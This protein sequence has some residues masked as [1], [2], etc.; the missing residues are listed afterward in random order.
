MHDPF[1]LPPI[2][3]LSEAVQPL[4]DSLHF[5]TLPLHIHEV[6]ISF[7]T[8]TFVDAVGAPF[9]SSRLFPVSYA[10]LS[11]ER[12][13]NW[14]VHVVS[15][16]QSVIINI[17]A[18]WIL[19]VDQ[20][21]KNM[22]LEERIWGYTGAAGMVQALAAGY[23]LWDLLISL[24]HIR[25]F[26]IGI[27]A[28]AVSA[29]V[30]FSFGFRPFVNYY[31]CTFILYELS[32][33]FLNF[34]W[35]FD[36]LGM[37]G[38]RAQLYNGILLVIT[39]FFCRLVWGTYQSIC[40]FQDIWVALHH[41]PGDVSV[42]NGLNIDNSIDGLENTYKHS[43]YS[44]NPLMRYSNNQYVPVW[45]SMVY[46]GSN[47]ILNFLNIYWFRQMIVTIRKRFQPKVEF[48]KKKSATDKRVT[49]KVE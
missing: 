38:S 42:Y 1:P 37:T 46:L 44:E 10:A 25:I 36:K 48:E 35:F 6:I 39:F 33:P 14:D 17:L 9:I 11:R 24:I 12:K 4:A 8:Y 18:L 31:G 29:L 26:G 13:I 47:F 2:S 27:F 49:G 7:L 3:W 34:H 15:L 5:S 32:S 20:E 41:Q 16:V 43:I 30:V 22:S 40:V 45:L 21:R 19:H 28:H 23:F